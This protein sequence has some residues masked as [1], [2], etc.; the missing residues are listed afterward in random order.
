[1]FVASTPDSLR[2]EIRRK[3][4]SLPQHVVTSMSSA[5]S[6]PTAVI[7]VPAELPAMA[8]FARGTSA[9]FEAFLV[10]LFPK[11]NLETWQSA[12][13]FLMMEQPKRFN[14]SLIA[15]LDRHGL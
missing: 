12:G 4:M 11:L 2:E 14:R 5:I 13:H 7:L 3:M 1:M 10:G 15:F 8:F 6:D 9:D